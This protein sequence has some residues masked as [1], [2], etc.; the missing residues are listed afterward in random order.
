MAIDFTTTL[1]FHK[2]E[3]AGRKDGKAPVQTT[4][5][6]YKVTAARLQCQPFAAHQQCVQFL[7]P[8]REP[9]ARDASLR[10]PGRRIGG[11]RPE[12]SP[13]RG[14]LIRRRERYGEF[15]LEM[16]WDGIGWDGMGW[17]GIGWHGMG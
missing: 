10:V 8:L 4:Y 5:F 11:G 16:G 3:T 13:L 1:R 14:K 7:L 9:I 15:C 6:W 12:V 2:A 17:D